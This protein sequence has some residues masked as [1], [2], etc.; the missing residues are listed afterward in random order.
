MKGITHYLTDANLI[1]P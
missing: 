1:F